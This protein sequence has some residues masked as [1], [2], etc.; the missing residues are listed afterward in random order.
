MNDQNPLNFRIFGWLA[1]LAA[2]FQAIG[3]I[4]YINRLPDD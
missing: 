4:R 2:L 1:A 3:L